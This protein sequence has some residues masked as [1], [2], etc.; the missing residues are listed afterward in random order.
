MSWIYE[1]SSGYLVS[2]SGHRMEPPGYAGHGA[3]VNNP[4]LENVRDVGPVPT[5]VYTM[6]EPFDSPKLG[7]FAI[8]LQPDP[9]NQMFGRSGFFLHGD[10]IAHQGEELASDGCIIQTLAIRQA[11]W[12]SLDHQLQVVESIEVPEAT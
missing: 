4:A 1:Q 11:A 5:G 12:N 10:E 9:A 7:R 3:G 8:Q 2:P 6:Q